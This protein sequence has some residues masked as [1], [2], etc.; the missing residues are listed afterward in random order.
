MYFKILHFNMNIM[1]IL[2]FI[3]SLSTLSSK[4]SL[5]NQLVEHGT[6]SAR[7]T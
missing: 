5:S 6:L 7:E 2:V 1:N 4:F 3:K